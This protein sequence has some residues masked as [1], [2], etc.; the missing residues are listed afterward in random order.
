M[1]FFCFCF[2]KDFDAV[3][4]SMGEKIFP[5][6]FVAVY[7]PICS[8][9]RIYNKADVLLLK[10]ATD[11]SNVLV[12]KQLIISCTVHIAGSVL[13]MSLAVARHVFGQRCH[14]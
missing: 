9:F 2:F 5:W 4:L 1:W 8:V 6:H 11:T 7:I 14:F 3:S 12:E 13:H 10:I